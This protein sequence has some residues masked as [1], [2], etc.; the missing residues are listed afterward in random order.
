MQQKSNYCKPNSAD[1]PHRVVDLV[2]G[3]LTFGIVREHGGRIE[4]VSTVGEGTTF[5]VVL[6]VAGPTAAP[7]S[8]A[9]V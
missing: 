2:G 5:A 4:V 9:A 8:C 7:A 3:G 6:P 1:R